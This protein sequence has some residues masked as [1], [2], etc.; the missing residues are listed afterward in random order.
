MHMEYRG[1]ITIRCGAQVGVRA[2]SWFFMSLEP[3]SELGQSVMSSYA[4]VMATRLISIPLPSLASLVIFYRNR[5]S[6]LF[7]FSIVY[8]YLCP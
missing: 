6:R 5:P 1:Y 4:A 8:H 2:V 3:V 7:R